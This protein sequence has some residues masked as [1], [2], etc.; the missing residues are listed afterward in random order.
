MLSL[1]DASI[2]ILIAVELVRRLSLPLLCVLLQSHAKTV[3]S[4]FHRFLLNLCFNPQDL[5]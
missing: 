4:R 1:F 5:T 2:L 3:L